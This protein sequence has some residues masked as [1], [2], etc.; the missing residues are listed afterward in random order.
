MS[1]VSPMP[2]AVAQNSEG[3]DCGVTVRGSPPGSTIS[4]DTTC[5]AKLPAT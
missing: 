1:P 3:S 2:P 4:N 5:R